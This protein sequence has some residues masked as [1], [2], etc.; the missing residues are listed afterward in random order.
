MHHKVCSKVQQTAARSGYFSD[1]DVFSYPTHTTSKHRLTNLH[2][3]Q[4]NWFVCDTVTRFTA[5]PLEKPKLKSNKR[6]QYQSNFERTCKIILLFNSD[7]QK[8]NFFR[9]MYS[10]SYTQISTQAESHLVSGSSASVECLVLNP[11]QFT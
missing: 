3:N 2:S 9:N 7:V 8:Y 11:I 10:N 5:F 4:F 1:L 6:V